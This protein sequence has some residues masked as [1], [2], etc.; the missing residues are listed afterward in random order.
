VRNISL[1]KLKTGLLLIISVLT[2]RV[3]FGQHNHDLDKS[4]RITFDNDFLNYRGDGTDRYYT[5]G[6]QLEY[7]YPQKKKDLF[8][9]NHLLEGDS[10]SN[11]IGH[12]SIVQLMFTPDNIRDSDVQYHNRPYAGAL[13][14]TRGLTTFNDG[15]NLTVHSEINIGVI[16]PFSYAQNM[17]TWIHRMIDYTKPSGW[18]HQ[19]KTDIV[20]NYNIDICKTIVSGNKFQSEMMGS[21]R[22][23]TLF[24]DLSVGFA[25]KAGKLKGQS[26]KTKIYFFSNGHLKL[27]LGNSLLQG[28]FIQSFKNGCADFYHINE[29]DIK[30]IVSTYE[31]GVVFN[32]AKWGFCF[33]QNFIS[34]EF[35]LAKTQ[36]FGRISLTYKI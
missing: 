15:L 19:I 35:R 4:I 25:V 11:K 2:A 30:R 34:A 3:S 8:S 24:N 36:L 27:V 10:D 26:T 17:Q 32:M 9:I 13:Y 31:T 21:S 23:G 5:N 6:L 7:S 14:I 1:S 33:S 18:S 16:G 22:A 20:L 28:G 12:L 29:D